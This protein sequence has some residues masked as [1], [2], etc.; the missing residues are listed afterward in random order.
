MIDTKA[1]DC[2]AQIALILERGDNRFDESR[3]KYISAIYD[4]GVKQRSS[5]S[6]LLLSK[7][8][9]LLTGYQSDLTLAE[10]NSM[11]LAR[12]IKMSFPESSDEVD[13]LEGNYS[14]KALFK[15]EE[16]LTRASGVGVLTTL[17]K[18]L[19][20]EG[21]F[22]DR[23]LRPSLI[24]RLQSQEDEVVKIFSANETCMRAKKRE[25]KTT[26]LFRES[27]EKLNSE[28]LVRQ[29]IKE[30][31]ENPGPINPH[32]LAIRSLSTMQT[33][34]PQYLKRFLA[35]IDTVFWLEQ[36]SE[37]LKPK[38]TNKRAVKSNGK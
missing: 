23:Q 18:L 3:F 31:P 13:L 6:V 22:D 32:M 17:T 25:L 1:V 36:A 5:V 35:Y 20:Q 11:A 16:R 24:E 14:S 19:L 34:S 26:R 38:A 9:K 15:L 8:Q 28:K 37:Q 33:L 12:R 10:E 30:G 2:A 7:V 4:R 27:Q 29:A 21:E